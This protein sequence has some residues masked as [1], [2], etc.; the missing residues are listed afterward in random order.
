MDTRRRLLPILACVLLS[1]GGL[2]PA[3][4]VARA[5]PCEIPLPVSE[6][7]ASRILAEE[8]PF[9]P[10]NRDLFFTYDNPDWADVAPLEESDGPALDENETRAALRAFLE[11]RFP[12]APDRVQEGMNV[13][14]NPI[15][16]Q[17]VPDPTLRAALAALTG[18]IGE[19]AIEFVLYETPV[20]LI[21]FGVYVDLDTGLQ[22]RIAGT[23]Q[24][25]DGTRS[26]VIDRVHRFLPFGAFSPLLVHEALHTGVGY[27]N[28]GYPEETI[29]I[30]IEA[31]VYMEMLLTDPSLAGL[32]DELT[33]SSNNRAALARLNSGPAGSDRLTLFVPGSTTNIDPLAV[34]PLTEFAELYAATSAPDDPEWRDRETQGNLLLWTILERLA[35]LGSTP[36]GEGTGF[37]ATT[38]AFVDQNQAVL[39]PA[40]LIAVACIL[41]LDVPC[42]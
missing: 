26:V 2:L 33:R 7:E 39:S 25:L 37:D 29:A 12:C 36:P 27:E 31:L 5:V 42:G 20:D 11:R 30:A 21:S 40:E 16:R 1:L 14:G 18:T 9:E 8:R 38:L 13:F 3:A 17:K 32:P 28:A 23:Y 34:E 22:D 35:E 41:E 15:A 10:V 4:P 19:P 6:E 24:S